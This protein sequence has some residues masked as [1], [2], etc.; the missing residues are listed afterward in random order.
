MFFLS[1]SIKIRDMNEVRVSLVIQSHLNDMMCSPDN[2]LMKAR[3]VFLKL[4]VSIYKDTSVCVDTN[5]ID[6]IWEDAYNAVE[7]KKVTEKVG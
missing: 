1:L 2:D 3:V 5:T 4:L 7:G 6:E